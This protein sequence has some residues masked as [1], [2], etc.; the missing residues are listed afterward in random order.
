MLLW[1]VAVLHLP[2]FALL[3]V[4][5]TSCS[6]KVPQEWQ[7][8]RPVTKKHE[9]HYFRRPRHVEKKKK[10]ASNKSGPARSTLAYQYILDHWFLPL[11]S[12]LSNK[13]QNLGGTPSILGGVNHF[14]PHPNVRSEKSSP[15]W[16]KKEELWRAHQKESEVLS[17]W[18]HWWNK[19]FYNF[20]DL[21]KTPGITWK[22]ESSLISDGISNGKNNK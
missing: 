1:P 15:Q 4:S 8:K 19:N 11:K 9:H 13:P 7:H 18:S 5:S 16:Q 20:L 6:N 3:Q 21:L 2:V 12:R 17:I 14:E 22:N 10:N